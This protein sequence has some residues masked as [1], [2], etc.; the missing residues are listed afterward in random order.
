MARKKIKNCEV[1]GSIE[2][3]WKIENTTHAMQVTY[4]CE[5]CGWFYEEMWEYKMTKLEATQ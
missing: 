4:A 2:I 5:A 3:A 1:C